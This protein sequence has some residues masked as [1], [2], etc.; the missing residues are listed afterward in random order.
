MRSTRPCF[1]FL[2]N[3]AG[4]AGRP[5]E[6]CRRSPGMTVAKTACAGSS[7]QLLLVR[8]SLPMRSEA[9]MLSAAAASSCRWLQSRC[10]LVLPDSVA[11]RT[12]T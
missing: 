10:D 9:T 1:E 5:M 2:P 8:M 6:P 11:G 12:D 4:K 7:D 3:Q